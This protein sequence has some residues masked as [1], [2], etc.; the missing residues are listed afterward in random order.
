MDFSWSDL[1]GN[2]QVDPGETGD[3]LWVSGGFDPANP[4][5]PSSNKVTETDAPWTNE[6]IVGIEREINRSFAVGGNF[7]Y[8][9]NSNFTWNPRDVQSLRQPVVAVARERG[10]RASAGA[11][12]VPG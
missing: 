2:G 12:T 10:R 7:I 6:L 8:K 11:N 3:L 5:A 1:N 9:K 4:T